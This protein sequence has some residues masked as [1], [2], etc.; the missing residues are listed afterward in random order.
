MIFYLNIDFTFLFSPSSGRV[1]TENGRS[2]TVRIF[3]SIATTITAILLIVP[4]VLCAEEPLTLEQALTTAIQH[5]PAITASRETANAAG[6]DVGT[7]AAGYWPQL[8]T[9]I[10]YRRGTAN[11]PAPAGTSTGKKESF[12]SYDNFSAALNLTVP[13][14][15]FGKTGGSHDAAKAR[16]AAG[17]YDVQS[18]IDDVCYSVTGSFFALL[19]A[20]E[21]VVSARETKAGMIKHLELAETQLSAGLRQKIDVSRA[22]SDLA[23]A[24]F[25]LRQSESSLTQARF[26]LAVAMGI[27]P[28]DSLDVR[29]PEYPLTVPETALAEAIRRALEKRPEYRSLRQKIAAADESVRVA[30]SNYYPSFAANG[31]FGYTGYEVPELVYNWSVGLSLNWDLFSGMGTMNAV[32]SALAQKRVLEAQL[33]SLEL[34]VG[35]EVESAMV[36]LRDAAGKMDPAAIAVS[37]AHETLLLAEERYGAGLGSIVEVADAQS[38]YTKAMTQKIQA[39]FDLEVA[40]AKYLRAIGSITDIVHNGK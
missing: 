36:G 1:D 17:D 39:A 3:T 29:A 8:S 14:Y 24:D 11:S 4:T 10:G 22:R 13:I 23:S 37:A 20:R 28:D 25:A 19:A 2:L 31:N 9:S 34:S 33:K 26:A 16:K 5:H 6:Y 21:A 7:A 35:N 30:R 27:A 40:R 12:S 32:S 18:E 38:A 15:D